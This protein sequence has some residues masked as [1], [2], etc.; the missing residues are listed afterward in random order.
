MVD[1]SRYPQ[2]NDAPH[3]RPDLTAFGATPLGELVWMLI[4]IAVIV[5]SLMAR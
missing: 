5:L 1:I 2:L 3:E 4:P